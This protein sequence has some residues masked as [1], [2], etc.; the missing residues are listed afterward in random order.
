MLEEKDESGQL[1]A[2]R[3]EIDWPSCLVEAIQI[4]N[5]GGEVEIETKAIKSVEEEFEDVGREDRGS[6]Y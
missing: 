2:L 1:V 4:P 5:T 6:E 3:L